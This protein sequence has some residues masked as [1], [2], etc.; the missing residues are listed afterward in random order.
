MRK[1]GFLLAGSF[2]NIAFLIAVL[3][4]LHTN[5][6]KNEVQAL[7]DAP[8]IYDLQRSAIHYG[9]KWYCGHPRQVLFSYFGGEEIITGHYHAPC[10]YQS[11]EDVR[12]GPKGYHGRAVA[13][14]QR[15]TDGG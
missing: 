15:S 4:Q 12:H 1:K 7:R 6:E 13:L 10:D 2:V 14:V 5:A 8:K 3:L 11:A 9:K